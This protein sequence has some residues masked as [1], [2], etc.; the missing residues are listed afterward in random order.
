M[1]ATIAFEHGWHTD[2]WT[3]SPLTGRLPCQFRQISQDPTICIIR[4]LQSAWQNLWMYPCL[5]T[6]PNQNTR[7]HIVCLR[8]LNKN[9]WDQILR[10]FGK[11][12]RLKARPLLLK[13]IPRVWGILPLTSKIGWSHG[14]VPYKIRD[15]QVIWNYLMQCWH[16]CTTSYCVTVTRVMLQRNYNDC[17]NYEWEPV[18]PMGQTLAKTTWYRADFRFAPSQ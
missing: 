11:M 13:G 7:M 4:D 14:L 9:V 1:I 18:L 17:W 3:T 8:S 5:S 6:T 10:C 16:R 15:C 2:Q 12:L